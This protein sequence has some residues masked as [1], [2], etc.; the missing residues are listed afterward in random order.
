MGVSIGDS[1]IP[2]LADLKK[3]TLSLVPLGLVKIGN[4]LQKWGANI[5][6]LWVGVTEVL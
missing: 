1:L 6:F 5:N 2:L 3:P 4:A